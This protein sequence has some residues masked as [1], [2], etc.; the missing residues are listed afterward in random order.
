MGKAWDDGHRLQPG[1]M[2]EGLSSPET[3]RSHGRVR[4]NAHLSSDGGRYRGRR[5]RDKGYAQ[6]GLWIGFPKSHDISKAIDK[7]NGMEREIVGSKRYLL[8]WR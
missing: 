2:D 4:G 6:L 8:P 3:G 1:T 5:F 7:M